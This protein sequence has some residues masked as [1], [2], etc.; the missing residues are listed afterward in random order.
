MYQPP[1]TNQFPNQPPP[2]YQQY[3][4]QPQEPLYQTS[5]MGFYIKVYPSHIEFKTGKGAQ[6]LPLAQIASVES[7]NLMAQITITTI[8]GRKHTIPTNKKAEAQQAI[9]L[10]LSHLAPTPNYQQPDYPVQ[11]PFPSQQ[12]IYQPPTTPIKKKPNKLVAII[13][14]VIVFIIVIAVASNHPSESS[15]TTTSTGNTT[16]TVANSTPVPTPTPTPV[17]TWQTTHTF[18]GNGIKKTET[19]TVASHWKLQ[20]TCDP[21]SF[22]GSMYNVI[23]SVYKDNATPLDYAAIN[24]LC[25][26]GNTS[27]ETEERAGGAIYLDINSEAAWT[28]TVQELK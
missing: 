15:N 1:S 16:A 19:I 21:T 27:G 17:P 8:T 4:N 2:N 26:D 5:Y 7:A 3:S 25:K 23:V 9:S 10:A 20:W 12:P 28:I 18:T 11:P 14:G 6:M 24:T 13:I 22:Y